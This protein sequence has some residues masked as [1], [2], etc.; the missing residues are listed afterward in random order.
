[1]GVILLKLWV[2]VQLTQSISIIFFVF[3]LPFVT[4]GITDFVV[5]TVGFGLAGTCRLFASI[6][7]HNPKNKSKKSVSSFIF[8][9]RKGLLLAWEN[10]KESLK[11]V[12]FLS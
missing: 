7:E 4:A 10:T 5:A 3:F 11:N 12:C 8:E 9:E 6:V 1:M 2:T